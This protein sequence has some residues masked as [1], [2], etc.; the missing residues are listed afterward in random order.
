MM[1]GKKNM[2]KYLIMLFVI[3]V[4]FLFILDYCNYRKDMKLLTKNIGLNSLKFETSLGTI[5]YSIEGEGEPILVIHGAGGGYDQGLLLAKTFTD[6]EAKMIA[7]S[8]PGFLGTPLTQ[9]NKETKSHSV[10][11]KDLI[12]E[13]GLKSVHVLA[14]SDGGPSAIQFAISYPEMCKTL[15]LV[16]C[17]SKTPP[18]ETVIQSL[19]FGNIFKADYLFWW[20]VNHQEKA[21]LESFGVTDNVQKTMDKSEIEL[22]KKFLELMQPMKLRVEGI[23][24]EREQ[25]KELNPKMYDL[26]KIL[27]KTLIIHAQDDTLQQY[28]YALHSAKHIPNSTLISYETGGHMLIGH[29]EEVHIIYMKFIQ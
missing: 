2:L 3:L 25:L 11:Y 9:S 1:K 20:M 21:L 14:F 4:A 23:Y 18:E 26:S 17:K 6:N 29:H 22:I 27:S 15:T 8:R 12:D 16:A 5:E 19:I 24:N 10:M 28:D 13:L 7:I